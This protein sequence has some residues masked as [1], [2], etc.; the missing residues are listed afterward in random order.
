MMSTLRDIIADPSKVLPSFLWLL[1]ER[2]PHG[3]LCRHASYRQT[4][5]MLCQVSC[6]S[7]AAM[8]S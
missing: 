4:W 8:A 3:T 7:S 2:R 6:Q 1:L 5:R